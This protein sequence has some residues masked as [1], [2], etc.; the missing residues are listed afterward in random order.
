MRMQRGQSHKQAETRITHGIAQ[1][2]ATL[3]LHKVIHE[4][5]TTSGSPLA[6]KL[7]ATLSG[8]NDYTQSINLGGSGSPLAPLLTSLFLPLKDL[9]TYSWSITLECRKGDFE[10]FGLNT[11][12]PR[13]KR[14]LIHLMVDI[15]YRKLNDPGN[16][17][18]ENFH[19][20]APVK[21]VAGLI[22]TLSKFTLYVENAQEG[23]PWRFNLVSTDP[24]GALSGGGVKPIVL[25]N[26]G[27]AT[28]PTTMGDLV[29][30]PAGLVFLGGGIVCLNL[31]RGWGTNPDYGEGF[32]LFEHGKGDG[33]YTTDWKDHMALLNW[34]QGTC[35]PGTSGGSKDW[36]DFVADSPRADLAK[37][38]SVFR[39]MGTDTRPSPTLVLGQV[40]RGFV[41]A[42]A[43]KSVRTPSPFA[44]GFLPYIKDA[45]RWSECL[46]DDPPEGVPT[47]KPFF[48]LV[49]ELKSQSTPQ[50]Q[51]AKY[52]QMFASDLVSSQPYNMGLAF[53]ATNHRNAFP[54][55]SHFRAG[56]DIIPLMKSDPPPSADQANAIPT[57]YRVLSGV[58]TLSDMSPFLEGM[59]IPGPRAAWSIHAGA[60]VDPWKELRIRGLVIPGPELSLDLNGWVV[61]DGQG[62]LL[63]DQN[64]SIVSN[65]GIVL[66]KGNIVIRKP[67][68]SNGKVFHFVTLDGNITIRDFFGDVEASL[69][70]GKGKVI[71]GSGTKLT[72]KGS[73]AMSRFDLSTASQGA[74]IKYDPQLSVRPGQTAD[75]D[76]EKPTL[77]I[78][79]D[80]NP[81]LVP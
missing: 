39:L 26:G 12:F 32:H 11:A 78:S 4:D 24:N 31:A 2:L 41:C 64:I 56:D 67:V 20:I 46:A 25:D 60:S 73:V 74:I 14:G 59:Q 80:P 66:R 27:D 8:M 43:F 42:K 3:A 79:V 16:G 61:F 1:A 38:N 68:K 49:P 18:E 62:D 51:L 36:F 44:P 70:A 45:S 35:V 81:L 77:C 23:D 48:D 21:V 19:F 50:G 9:G 6:E 47:L 17:I 52:Q 37:L 29:K 28:I 65:G 40:F 10:A 22:P 76:S 5:L 69:V 53:I 71:V 30:K 63:V 13:E 34:D 57:D 75:A 33:L 54:V 55:S 72:I 7:G 58:T 15:S